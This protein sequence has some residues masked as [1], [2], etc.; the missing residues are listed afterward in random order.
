M[1]ENANWQRNITR[2]HLFCWRENHGTIGLRPCPVWSKSNLAIPMRFQLYHIVSYFIQLSI[3]A[4]LVSHL[5]VSDWSV[6]GVLIVIINRGCYKFSEHVF[7]TCCNLLSA[8]SWYSV[9]WKHHSSITPD[10]QQH[11]QTLGG[12]IAK[13]DCRGKTLL[14]RR[15]L[16]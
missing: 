2:C 11:L 5:A 4:V 3:Q 6:W 10:M 9:R 14:W 13:A 16:A 1:N 12:C 7:I 15:V 8:I